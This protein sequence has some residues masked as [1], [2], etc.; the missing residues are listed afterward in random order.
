MRSGILK[1]PTTAIYLNGTDT[2]QKCPLPMG[3]LDTLLT[4]DS[5]DPYESSSKRHPDRFSR[6]CTAH[7]RVSRYFTMAIS[8]PKLPLP[9]G[10]SGP[11]LIHG[12]HSP[13]ESPSQMASQSAQANPCVAIGCYC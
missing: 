8:P 11:H 5:L 4:H 9:I 13:P 6:F 12:T 7:C 10:G 2:P 3:D 1:Q